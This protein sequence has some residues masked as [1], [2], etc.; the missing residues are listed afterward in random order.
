MRRPR[1]AA[2]S[3]GI[4]LP[5]LLGV[6]PACA[7]DASAPAA[8][9]PVTAVPPGAPI[10][11]YTVVASY[12]RDATCFIEGFQWTGSGF[13]E[14]CGLYGASSVRQTNLAGKVLRRAAL[15]KSA[16]G[17]GLVKL[18]TKAYVMTW[19]ERLVYV[20]DAT[21]LKDLGTRPMPVALKEGWGMTSDGTSL[22][23][24]DGTS[25][26]RWID[27]KTFAVTR[28]IVVRDG[29]AEVVNVNELELI[30]GEL[31]ANVWTTDRIVRIDPS[32]G[33]VRSV[34]DLT[35][36]RPAATLSEPDSV[37]NGIAYDAVKKRIFVTGKKWDKVFEIRVAS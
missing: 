8:A 10:V 7:D 15:P 24:S 12:P 6:V 27:P 32:T 9:V 25:T 19:K 13:L 35:G 33:V 34:V 3:A 2:L 26:I 17:E 5:L 30:N 20:R 31:W 29:A 16:F 11:G 4:L 21:T 14:S 1:A 37:L 22:I 28:S 23:A 36:L 18:G